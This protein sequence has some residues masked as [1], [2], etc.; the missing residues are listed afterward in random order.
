MAFQPLHAV[1]KSVEHQTQGRSRQVFQLLRQSWVEVVGAM[2]AEQ[3]RPITLQRQVLMVA[4]SSA[5]W[6][7][8]LA[9]ERSRLIE[10]LNHRLADVLPKGGIQDIRFSTAQWQTTPLPPS[11]DWMDAWHHHPSRIPSP[12]P[13]SSTPCL[14]ADAQ[15]AFQHWSGIIQRRSQHLPL[16]PTC[17]CPTPPGELQRW[18]VCALCAPKQWQYTNGRPPQA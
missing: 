3:T 8:T 12:P 10:K 13:P 6:A 16:C 17:Q 15:A 4:T 11:S 7:Q 5:A 18:S 1:M 14:Q 2:V 9:F